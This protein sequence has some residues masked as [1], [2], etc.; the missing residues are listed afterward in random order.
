MGGIGMMGRLVGWVALSPLYFVMSCGNADPIAGT[1]TAPQYNLTIKGKGFDPHGGALVGVAVFD[2]TLRSVVNKTEG[3]VSHDGLFTLAM[4]QVLTD[5]GAYYL[6]FYTDMNGNKMCDSPPTDHVWKTKIDDVTGD[7]ERLLEHHMGFEDSCPSFLESK[8]P[9]NAINVTISGTLKLSDSVGSTEGLKGGQVLQGATVFLQGFPSQETKTNSQG[10]FTLELK[11]PEAGLID[12][13]TRRKLVMWYTVP[14]D[15]D[16][17]FKWS[18]STARF[19]HVKDI[20]Y[21]AGGGSV[22]LGGVDLTFTKAMILPVI[23]HVTGAIVSGCWIRLPDFGFQLTITQNGDGHYLIDYLPPQSY[24][25]DVT[26]TGYTAQ[27]VT[28]TVSP[29]TGI[30]QTETVE[31]VRLE[32]KRP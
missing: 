16:D 12:D 13:S 27:S 18:P 28:R 9:E 10:Q 14:Q 4:D 26:C 1:L 25:I 3:T 22:S 32:R 2:R 5:R 8:S 15:A 31:A 11:I 17:P 6:D 7:T 20:D 21:P 30:E 24:R 19:G 29:A 23:D